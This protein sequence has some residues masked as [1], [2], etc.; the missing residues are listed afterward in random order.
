MKEDY[1]DM[2]NTCLKLARRCQWSQCKFRRAVLPGDIVACLWDAVQSDSWRRGAPAARTAGWL[3]CRCQCHSGYI[4]MGWQRNSAVR[5]IVCF[6]PKT[7]WGRGTCKP[8]GKSIFV[9]LRVGEE[10][11]NFPVGSSLRITLCNTCGAW[12]R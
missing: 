12:V 8:P 7:V 5:C 1:G 11:L 2:P 6:I 4:P 9:H 10:M 3:G